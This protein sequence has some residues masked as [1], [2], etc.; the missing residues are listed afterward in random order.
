MTP[1][2]IIDSLNEK[3]FVGLLSDDGSSVYT[4]VCWIDDLQDIS[5][6]TIVC[7]ESFTEFRKRFPKK[8]L[9]DGKLR[10]IGEFWLRHPRGRINREQIIERRFL[11]KNLLLPS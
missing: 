3:F 7:C 2:E 11:R 8:Q 4:R 6:Q 1:D 9:I 10:N 5:G